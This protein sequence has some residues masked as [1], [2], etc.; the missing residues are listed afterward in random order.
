MQLPRDEIGISDLL[1]HRECPRRMSWA[2]RRHLP[3]GEPPEATTPN[4]AYGSAVHE[5]LHASEADDLTDEQA[6]LTAFKR[7]SRWLDPS[8]V[9]QLRR[10][11]A[12]Y[13]ERDP[14]LGSRTALNEGEIRVP[15]MEYGGRTIFFRAKIDRLYQ[16]LDNGAVFTHVDYK[17][18]KW[19]KT[20]EEIDNDIQM[21]AYNW[22]IHEFFPECESLTQHYDQLRGGLFSTHKS[23]EQRIL[24]RDWLQLAAIALIDDEDYDDDGLLQPQYNEWCPWCAIKMDCKVVTG[25]LTRFAEATI[26]G[27]ANVEK[28]KRKDGSDGKREVMKL[29][30][31]MIDQY[32]EV[33][34]KVGRAK[35]TLEAFDKEVRAALRKMPE[36][37]RHALGVEIRRK[38]L[39]EYGPAELRAIHD[40]VGDDDFY[41]LVGLTLASVERYY[42]D[43]HPHRNEVERLASERDGAISVTIRSNA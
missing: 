35:R 41:A 38:T 25:D 26:R 28:V 21:W 10:D 18:S 39:R 12:L 37:T 33:L 22:C 24:I 13:H 19:P 8:D 31:D 15:L 11:L 4:D 23:A 29:D 5:A 43:D 42:P 20:Q 9:D 17:S 2:M 32:V 36:Q 34:P 30:I 27:L 6:I 1:A 40:L 14:G 3:Q 7:Y 16:R